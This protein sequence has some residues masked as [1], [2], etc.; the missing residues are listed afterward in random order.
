MT[1]I[2][3]S[4]WPRP[5]VPPPHHNNHRGEA[6]STDSKSRGAGFHRVNASP[7]QW[8]QLMAWYGERGLLWWREIS[9]TWGGKGDE[10]WATTPLSVAW[11][12][13]RFA[14]AWAVVCEHLRKVLSS[15]PLDRPPSPLECSSSSLGPSW[16]HHG[17]WTSCF[18]CHGGRLC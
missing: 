12:P 8:E 4:R 16:R 18:S 2:A 3:I 6:K 5:L 15:P 11:R 7:L 9:T 1:R 14:N 17:S 10:K 13:H